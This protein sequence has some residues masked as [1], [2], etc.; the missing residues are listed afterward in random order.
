MF[1]ESSVVLKAEGEKQLG[2]FM[3]TSSEFSLC[4]ATALN[5]PLT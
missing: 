5:E 1:L 2:K 3:L 4:L